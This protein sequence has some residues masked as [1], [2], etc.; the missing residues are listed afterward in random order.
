MRVPSGDPRE[1]G[2]ALG[3]GAEG[4]DQGRGEDG[5]GEERGGGEGPSGLLAGE[6]EVGDG[7]ADTAVRLREGEARQ[8]E[9]VGEGGPQGGVVSGGGVEGG[10]QFVR[11]GA[12]AEQF[13]QCAADLVLFGGEAGVH[14]RNSPRYLTARHIRRGRAGFPDI[15][16]LPNAAVADVPSDS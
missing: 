7:A 5:G 14:G 10:T 11:A 8:A 9:V 12:L 1:E 2:D 15:R 16:H 3:V 6:G 4:E 13:A